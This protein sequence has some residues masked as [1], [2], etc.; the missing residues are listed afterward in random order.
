MFKKSKT[1]R[2]RAIP[3]DGFAAVGLSRLLVPELARWTFESV[4]VR[5]RVRLSRR[6]Q[7]AVGLGALVALGLTTAGLVAKRT[8][9][10]S[11]E[12]TPTT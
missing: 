1:A 12:P 6:Q 8:I 3:A 9:H 2:L 7:Q 11:D 4:D 5:R 10:G